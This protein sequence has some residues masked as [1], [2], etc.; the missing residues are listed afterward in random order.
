M[1]GRRMSK[2]RIIRRSCEFGCI[3]R[4][5]RQERDFRKDHH[6][7]RQLS[8]PPFETHKARG[9]DS[10]ETGPVA[11]MYRIISSLQQQKSRCELTRLIFPSLISPPL[12][13]SMW[14]RLLAGS[15]G[16]RTH[17]CAGPRRD[18][19]IRPPSRGHGVVSF[20]RRISSFPVAPR[21]SDRLVQGFA[22]DLPARGRQATFFCHFRAMFPALARH[23]SSGSG[24][25]DHTW[26]SGMAEPRLTG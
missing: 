23:L 15:L 6:C 8:S 4:T 16:G 3:A 18:E 14:R 12:F 26:S 22:E 10:H 13:R 20:P 11:P 17:R 9:P 1:A 2:R 24:A 7:G 21:G 5:L 19:A 25:S